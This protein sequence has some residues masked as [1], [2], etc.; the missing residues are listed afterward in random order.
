MSSWRL[1]CVVGLVR[2]AGLASDSKVQ[3][4]SIERPNWALDRFFWNKFRVMMMMRL[5]EIGQPTIPVADVQISLMGTFRVL[6]NRCYSL[7]L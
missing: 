1:G 5:G 6:V 4:K 7:N 2:S 3:S